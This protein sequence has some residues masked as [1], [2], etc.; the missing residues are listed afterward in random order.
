MFLTLLIV[1]GIVAIV[2]MLLRINASNASFRSEVEK[3]LLTNEMGRA[4]RQ[5]SQIIG[6]WTAIG[7]D[8]GNESTDMITPSS[9]E[10]ETLLTAPGKQFNIAAEALLL[11]MDPEEQP[12][13]DAATTAHAGLLD[14]A[15][16]LDRLHARSLEVMSTYRGT[17]QPLEQELRSA[18][19][20]LR[21]ESS[22]RVAILIN[23]ASNAETSIRI[24]LPILAVA[25]LGS[26]LALSML[27]SARRK[28][29][30]LQDLVSAKDEFIASV[31][32]ELR[33]PLTGVVGFAVE[34]EDW[35]KKQ[36]DPEAAELMAIIVDEAQQAAYLV[37]DLL[38]AARFEIDTVEIRCENIE[39]R[40]LVE[41][42]VGE[43]VLRRSPPMQA[44]DIGSSRVVAYADPK[45]IRQ[46]LR[47]LFTNAV[48]YGGRRDRR[49]A[50]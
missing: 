50:V 15:R 9:S 23:D 34:L 46:I 12:T 45:R 26:T 32:H 36:T 22:Q 49:Q 47:N 19:G 42:V 20:L 31:S 25:A 3:G 38:V 14:S 17:M 24:V 4:V 41:K 8:N 5:E 21:M 2:T 48:H 6:A 7:T 29:D 40:S 11:L 13:L 27:K 30:V 43:S 16:E 10:L 37:E 33:T 28:S 35:V 18:I 39:L 1:F 44:M